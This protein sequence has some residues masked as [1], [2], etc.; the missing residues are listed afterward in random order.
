MRVSDSVIAD[1][2]SILVGLIVGIL[3]CKVVHESGH[4]LTASVL[5]GRI[6]AV[7]VSF[8][9]RFG[10]FGIRY[11]E[12]GDD[13][14]RGLATLMGTGATTL[15]AY[16]LVLFLLRWRT[17][18]WLRLGTLLVAWICAWDM[19]LYATL[20]LLGLRRGLVVGGR[21]AEPVEGAELMGVPAWLFLI[22]LTAS[23][24]AF[25]ALAYRAFRGHG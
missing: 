21:H 2:F 19:F 18:L 9:W 3:V 23:F 25:H 22:G 20:P 6:E 13:W 14:R 24:V 4:A 16:I 11:A 10:F 12:P 15:V 8:P 7:R 17:P 1:A 5:G